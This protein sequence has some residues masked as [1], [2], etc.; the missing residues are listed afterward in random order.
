MMKYA[1]KIQV[2]QDFRLNPKDISPCVFLETRNFE[3]SKN[4]RAYPE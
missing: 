1:I 3:L 4:T 2:K